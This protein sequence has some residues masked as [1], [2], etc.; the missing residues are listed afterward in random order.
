MSIGYC[1]KHVFNAASHCFIY[2]W[3]SGAM[4]WF[5]LTYLLDVMI[6]I[7]VEKDRVILIP[8]N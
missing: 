2:I 1:N 4:D 5:Q 6:A 7:V 3:F 8:I